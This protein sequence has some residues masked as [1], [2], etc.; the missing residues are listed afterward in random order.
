[1]RFC[2]RCGAETAP[3]A[4]YCPKCGNP[5]QATG[6][7][8]PS[9]GETEPVTQPRTPPGAGALAQPEA[10]RS[11]APPLPSTTRPQTPASPP[12]PPPPSGYQPPS[13]RRRDGL[14]VGAVGA[15][16][17]LI[18]AV[19]AGA[20][21]LLSNHKSSHSGS[22]PASANPSVAAGANS[23]QA[24]A[25]SPAAATSTV[26]SAA[27]EQ[28]AI[29]AVLGEYQATYSSHDISGLS[30]ILT[31]GVVRHGLTSTGCRFDRGRPA[32]LADYQSQFADGSG[33]YRLVG[34]AASGIELRGTD[35]AH[36]NA[37]YQISPGGSGAVSFTL[38]REGNEWK[39]SQVY[40]TC[41]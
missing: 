21:L 26:P 30:H 35:A 28:A 6:A 31:E 23:A 11:S 20:A 12:S 1:V 36:V 3:G 25:S 19:G 8:A 2:G 37:H 4:A 17:V 14:P 10:A 9:L 41:A 5:L 32:V 16:V 13:G 40:A 33:T 18:A 22:K 34:L 7:S 39:I 15:I 38:A 24:S 27:A 29:L